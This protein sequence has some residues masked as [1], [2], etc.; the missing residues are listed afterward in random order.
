MVIVNSTMEKRAFQRTTS[1]MS[2]TFCC[3]ITDFYSG[4]L[5]N[6]S[7]KGMFISTPICFPLGSRL[8]MLINSNIE[9]LNIPV[10]VRWMRK[11]TDMYDGIGVEVLELTN[12]YLEFVRSINL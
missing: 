2:V 7:E 12:N 3:C 11:S 4:T 8:N 6:I 5:T 9:T 1:N 10:R